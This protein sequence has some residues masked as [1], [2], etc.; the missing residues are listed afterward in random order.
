MLALGVAVA[1]ATAGAFAR[2]GHSEF[3]SSKPLPSWGMF[4]P[5]EWK[6]VSLRVEHRGFH[7]AS[8]H[9][10]G[11]T[12]TTKGRRFGLVAGRSRTG[13]MCVTPVTGT[14]LRATIC[15]LTKPLI[16][17]TA[18]QTWKVGAALGTP[19]H[20]MHA[21]AVVGIARHD[22]AG[23]VVRDSLDHPTGMTLIQTGR[24]LT[25][26]TGFADPSSLSVY[27]AKGRLLAHLVLRAP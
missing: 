9:L 8:I 3:T 6:T 20:V 16:L 24:L 25:F 21:T 18:P 2:A 23:I 22:V 13:A 1:V 12:D 7:A 5:A 26:A 15:R 11:V 17:F 10:V 14:A 4:T 19:A 27:N